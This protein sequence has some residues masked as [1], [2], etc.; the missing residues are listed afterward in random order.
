MHVFIHV[1]SIHIHSLV[2]ELDW[3]DVSILLGMLIP[4]EIGFYNLSPTIA[5][6]IIGQSWDKEF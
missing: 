2:V 1:I 6:K 4:L 5:F 3:G